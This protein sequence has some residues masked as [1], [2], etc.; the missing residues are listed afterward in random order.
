LGVLLLVASLRFH[1]RSMRIVSG[2][3][4]FVTVLKVFLFDMANLEGLAPPNQD[5]TAAVAVNG[6]TSCNFI[7]QRETCNKINLKP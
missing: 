3:L 4:V 6:E 2:V 1:S 7:I 5:P